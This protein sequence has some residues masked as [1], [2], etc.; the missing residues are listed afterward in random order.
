MILSRKGNIM[1][2][3]LT[4]F[5]TCWKFINEIN[6]D[7]AFSEPMLQTE[8]Q[9]ED[10]LKSA[11]TSQ[12]QLPFG[13]FLGG[14]MKGLFVFQVLKDEQYIEMQ[15]GL[16][17]EPDAYEEMA[18]WLQTHYS[19]YQVDFVF[20]P[21]NR[22]IRSMLQKR[23]AIFFPEQIKMVLTEDTAS[24]D[25]TGIEPLSEQYR[26]QY[27]AVHSTD[28]Y[29]TGDK[30]ANA[31]D[32]FNVFLAIEDGRVVGYLDVTW[33][34]EENEAFDLLVREDSRRRGWGRKLLAKAIEANR[35]KGLVVFVDVD[36]EAAIALYRS[37]GFSYDPKPSS[38]VATWNID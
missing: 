3:I 18:D 36:N 5:D 28:V 16:S 1:I 10:N 37:M 25:L 15:V 11:L 4:E 24:V 13:V 22:A 32:M 30:V 34:Y 38:Q 33:N 21:K 26:E 20:N 27:L 12:D 7:P 6:A 35:S 8:E 2:Q 19:G 29:W 23:E 17:R 9:M 14:E 31:L